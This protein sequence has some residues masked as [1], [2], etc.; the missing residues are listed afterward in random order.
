MATSLVI[1]SNDLKEMNRATFDAFI[2]SGNYALSKTEAY[3][4][5]GKVHIE[6]L[7]TNKLLKDKSEL[8]GKCKFLLS[9]IIA[10]TKVWEKM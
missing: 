1:T 7:I 5:F 8:P 10:A 2:Q 6:M 3:R 4:Q 9:D